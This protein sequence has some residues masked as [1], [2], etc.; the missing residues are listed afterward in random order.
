MSDDNILNIPTE[1]EELTTEPKREKVR[2][3]PI[4]YIDNFPEHPFKVRDDENMNQLVESIRDFGVISPIV[5][6][7][8]PDERYEVISG[9]RRKYA[10]EKLGIK[11]MPVILR[12]LSREEAIIAMVDSNLQREVILPSEKAF[13]YKMKMEAIDRQGKRADLKDA[14]TCRP[15]VDKLKSADVIGSEVGESG[16]QIQRYIRL[17]ELTHELLEKVDSGDIAFRPAVEL[18]Y[19]TEEE[20]RNLLETIESEEATP[21]L[22]QA[23]CMKKLSQ[24]K[25][26]NMDT[27]FDIMTEEKANQIEKIKIPMERIERY[28]TRGTPPKEIEETIIKALDEYRNRQRARAHNEHDRD[29]R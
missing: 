15:L 3:I 4:Q 9:H 26:L 21:S 17:T 22:G 8:K 25:N 19:L 27:I 16:R 1:K 18:S 28:F 2:V 7:K 6:I 12:E 14:L 5:C 23:I 24:E 13:A 20:Q 10:C 29:E 11:V